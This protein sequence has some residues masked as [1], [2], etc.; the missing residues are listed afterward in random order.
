MGLGCLSVPGNL[1]SNAAKLNE[2]DLKAS[3]TRVDNW[4]AEFLS[5]FGCLQ[6][7]YSGHS[8]SL[9]LFSAALPLLNWKVLFFLAPPRG[10]TFGDRRRRQCCP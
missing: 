3:L 6:A 8:P 2:K 10:R 1:D 5:C 4:V 7:A 9:L